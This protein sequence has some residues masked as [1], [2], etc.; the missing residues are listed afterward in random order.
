MKL[1]YLWILLF[2]AI[3]AIMSAALT[4]VVGEVYA[5]DAIPGTTTYRIS[6]EFDDPA[7]QC[8]AQYGLDLT[9]LRYTTTTT[10]Y[11]NIGGQ[12]TA[13][14][15]TAALLTP[16]PDLAYD[17]F[18]TVG[19]EMGPTNLTDIGFDYSA[20]EAGNDWVVDDIFGGLLFNVPGDPAN[21]PVGGRVLLAQL[22]TDGEI[23]LEINIQWRDPAQNPI[24]SA[25]YIINLPEVVPGCTDPNALNFDA[26]ATEDDGSCTYPAPSF[27]GLTYEEVIV[28]GVAGF[29]TY[30]VYANFTNPFDQLTAVYGQDVAPLSV[31]T[32]GSFYQDGAGG[33]TSVDVSAA[34]I[35]G[36]PSLA[37][38]SWVT[39][40]AEDDTN[41]NLQSLGVDFTSFE[42]GGALT[43]N[44]A[45]GAA[46]FVFPDNQP[47]AFPDMMGRVLIGQFTTDG[48]VDLTMNLQYRAQDGTNP[49]EEGLT[50]SFPPVINGC[51]DPTADNYNPNANVD[52]G[53]CEFSGCTDPT[54]DN[55]DPNAN[56]DD[57]SC[58]FSGC[59][60]PTADNF[61]PNANVDDGSCEFSG[62]TDPT[63]DNFDPN[64]NVDDGSCEF[65]GCTEPTADNFDPNA[66]VDDGSCIVPGCTYTDATNYDMTATVDDGSCV[67]E[68]GG[69]T[70]PTALNFNPGANTDDGSCIAAVSGC[71]DGTATNYD[72]AANV[73]DGSCIATVFGCTDP[74]AF[75]FDAAANVDNGGC[76]AVMPGCTDPT[77]NNYNAYANT[78]DGTC[79]FVV[80]CEGDFNTD[81][82]I[83][84]ADLLAFLSVFGT[85]C[86]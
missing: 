57:G 20:F 68:C 23:E 60:D 15:V 43:I 38:D 73:D 63:A 58:E 14:G 2:M 78:D 41:N 75:N 45:A 47:S 3:P 71:T 53:S 19:Y 8:V 16:F 46:W 69:C 39:I 56:V 27:T 82:T 55:F 62:C 86:N 17:S 67:F 84:A 76:V 18:L 34:A 51:T 12:A 77:A 54:A 61:D 44:D 80:S 72:P 49:Q 79:D 22:T 5:V 7:D 29:T 64:A 36:V 21:F 40:G 52:D 6:A 25:G 66:N 1:R 13:E 11:Q 74:T 37:Y 9:P 85:D 30:R 70:D 28:D 31:T 35:P 81:G 33:P 32:T 4:G 26:I 50:L 48:F 24:E 83:N 10:W 65:L 59:T 42:A